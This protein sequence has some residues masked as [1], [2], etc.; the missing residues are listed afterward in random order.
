MQSDL[1][2]FC[3]STYTTISIDSV[4]GQQRPC[5]GSALS[6]NCL[7]TI[8][9]VACESYDRA[10]NTDR[11]DEINVRTISS[12][13]RF[14]TDINIYLMTDKLFSEITYVVKNHMTTRVITPAKLPIG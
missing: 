5:L 1:G 3:Y 8:S 2:I 4:S 9:C 6:A 7:R 14:Y 10:E 11:Q 13:K 12:E